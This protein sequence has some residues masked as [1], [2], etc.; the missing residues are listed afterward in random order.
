MADK[1]KKAAFAKYTA[2]AIAAVLIIGVTVTTI[3]IKAKRKDVVVIEP[4]KRSADSI[5]D[6]SANKDEKKDREIVT[7]R[8]EVKQTGSSE[9]AKPISSFPIDINKADFA[10]LCTID[11]VGG[12]TAQRILDYRSSVGVIS[13]LDMLLNVDGIGEKTLKKLE[14][15]LFVSEK[16]KA[17]IANAKTTT[18][19]TVKNTSKT[20]DRSYKQV[21]INSAE[22]KEIAQA[23]QIS[24][25]KAQMIV[26][27]RG[28]IG[29][30][31]AKPQILLSKA[32]S[33][34][35]FN[36]LEQYILV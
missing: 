2:A 15:Y 8:S 1:S 24:I 18:V 36:K 33:E 30:Y 20:D 28:K 5:K 22:A 9:A 4:N 34:D 16:D 23:L 21:N 7:K 35:E 27:T 31:V 19:T 10:Q 29:G 32:I 12:S 14:N 3:M 6:S 13:S 11:G 26:E 17:V 25:D